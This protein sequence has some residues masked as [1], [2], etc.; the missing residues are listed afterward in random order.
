L[1][2]SW[3]G[4]IDDAGTKQEPNR[5]SRASKN[6]QKKTERRKLPKGKGGEKALILYK[7]YGQQ[8]KAWFVWRATGGRE[9]K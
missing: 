5:P 9:R 1:G 6:L 4:G 7:E 3:E 2:M 8:G